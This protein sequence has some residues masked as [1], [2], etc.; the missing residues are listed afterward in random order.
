MPEFIKHVGQINNTGKKCVVV[1]R[2]I[3]GEE[4]SCLVVETEALPALYHDDLISS[5]ES[6]S[7]QSD[8]DFYKFAQ[9]STFH[10]G[11]NM[12]ESLHLKGLLRKVPATQITMLP[13]PDVTILLS[14]LN[15][16][17]SQLNNQG[18]TT[19]S[20]INAPEALIQE[21]SNAPGTLSDQQIA[22][23]MRSQAH[24]FRSEAERLLKEAES[25]DPSNQ[26]NSTEPLVEKAKRKYTKKK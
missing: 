13:T 24:Y 20:D 16:Q 22:N 18:R 11:T 2:E 6:P 25:L 3:P 15:K 19:S 7:A 23:Q 10:D 8:M 9:R 21:S 12:L 14:E 1:F 5:V 4:S 26:V 17:I